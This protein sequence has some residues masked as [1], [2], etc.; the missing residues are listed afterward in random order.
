MGRPC[1][2]AASP[3]LT[4]PLSRVLWKDDLGSNGLGYSAEVISK[5][6][7]EGAQVLLTA[8]SKMGAEKV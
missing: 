8:D 3:W 5:A 7:A 4:L 6:K 2:K 1:C